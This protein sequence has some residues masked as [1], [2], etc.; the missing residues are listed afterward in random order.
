MFKDL[1]SLD[2]DRLGK[3]L[4][5]KTLPLKY[6]IFLSQEEKDKIEE[7]AKVLRSIFDV[8]PKVSEYRG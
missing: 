3:Y 2:Q 4:E 1:N 7:Q 6:N 5:Q 8:I